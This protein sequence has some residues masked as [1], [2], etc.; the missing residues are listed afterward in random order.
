VSQPPP[1]IG[2]I[3]ETSLWT[4]GTASVPVMVYLV[5]LSVPPVQAAPAPKPS[6][7]L[8]PCR[9]C[10]RLSLP[11]SRLLRPATPILPPLMAPQPAFWKQEARHENRGQARKASPESE[12][13]VRN[14]TR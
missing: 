5:Y 14:G 7:P 13:G 8:P 4:R 1:A 10:P 6:W 12:S 11:P 9:A 3:V 2:E